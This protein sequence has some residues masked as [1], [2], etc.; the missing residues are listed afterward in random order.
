M[1]IEISMIKELRAKTGAGVMDC[2]NALLES[3]GNMEQAVVHLHEKGLA[4][5]AKRARK[6]TSEGLVESYVHFGGKIGVLV[7]VNCETEFVAKTKEFQVFAHDI[8]MHIAASNPFYLTREDVPEEVLEKEKEIYRAEA[9][10]KGKPENVMEKIVEG[11]ME[12][13][14]SEACLMDQPFIKD[15]EL[16][17]NQLLNEMIGKLKENITISRFVRYQ[18]GENLKPEVDEEA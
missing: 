9:K 17:I 10:G 1:E 4:T 11:K 6:I 16:T 2:K 13:F 7:E 8:A 15:T 14:Y 3:K 18:L 12:K 5:V